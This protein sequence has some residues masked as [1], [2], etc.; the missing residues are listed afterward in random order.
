LFV[1]RPHACREDEF[2]DGFS[3]VGGGFFGLAMS[4][5]CS[6]GSRETCHQ[7]GE[8]TDPVMQA[9]LQM[10]KIDLKTL[11]RTFRQGK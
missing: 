7:D 10:K 8:K 11:E 9:I 3:V 1:S 5:S 6:R 2:S 4:L